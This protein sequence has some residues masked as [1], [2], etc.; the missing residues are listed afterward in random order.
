MVRDLGSI[1]DTAPFDTQKSLILLKTLARALQ[2]LHE[3]SNLWDQSDLRVLV[4]DDLSVMQIGT[5]ERL[6][7]GKV[8][9]LRA[10]IAPEYAASGIED[11]CGDLWAWGVVAYEM[12][13]GTRPF[14]GRTVFET[15]T[16]NIKS[17]AVPP[18]DIRP[19]CNKALSNVILMALRREPR[20]RFRA[21]GQLVEALEKIEC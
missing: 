9:P 10:S 13:T 18:I 5:R 4:A 21:A 7:P 12:V 8:D 14:T 20:E 3:Q 6:P 1:L 19:D 16:A 2:H 15:M 17:E 11:V